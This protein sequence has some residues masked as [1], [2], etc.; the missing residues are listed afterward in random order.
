MATSS[1]PAIPVVRSNDPR[2]IEGAL[3]AIRQRFA[4]LER[5]IAATAAQAGQSSFVLSQSN[6]STA[7]LQAQISTLANQVA[8]L[9]VASGGPV[10]SYRADVAVDTGDAVFMSSDAGVSVVDPH[11]PTTIFGLVGVAT[12]SVAAGAQI[13][14]RRSGVH[15]MPLASLEPGRAVYAQVGGGLTQWPSYAAV[16]VPVGVALTPTTMAVAPAWPAQRDLPFYPG[17]YEDFLPATL[18]LVRD[19]V[20]L[21]QALLD[22]PDGFVVKVGDQLVTRALVAGSGT[23][24]VIDNGDGV[25]GDALFALDA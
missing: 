1:G 16:A 3:N 11:D 21:L 14:V 10:A 18:G 7:N 13:M 6:A 25:D 15:T 9:E 17:G 22:Q 20:E 4:V 12:A 19:V 23:G 5:Q 24:I 2:S 8:A